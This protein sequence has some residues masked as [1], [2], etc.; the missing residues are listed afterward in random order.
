VTST[1]LAPPAPAS[2]PAASHTLALEQQ[3][4]G[5]FARG[6]LHDAADFLERAAQH[7]P[8]APGLWNRLGMARHALGQFELARA[9]SDRLLALLPQSPVAWVNRAHTLEALQL[10]EEALACV[11]R[12]IDCDARPAVHWLHRGLVLG[13]LQRHAD[14]LAA[15]DQALALDE[16]LA[17]AWAQRAGPL[18][19]AH[20]HE[21]ALASSERALALDPQLAVGWEQRGYCLLALGQAATALECLETAVRLDPG[22]AAAR[23]SRGA[24]LLSLGQFERGWEDYEVRAAARSALAGSDAP[25][26]NPGEALAGRTLALRAEQGLG[27]TLQFCRYAAV[28]AR[29]GTPVVLTAPRSLVRLLNSLGGGVRVVPEDEPLPPHALQCPL[30]SLPQRLGTCADTIPAAVPYLAPPAG[31]LRAWSARLADLHP[32]GRVRVGLAFSG[33]SRFN[34]DHNRSVPP[35]RLAALVAAFPQVEWHLLQRDVRPGDTEWIARLGLV[36]HRAMLEDFCETAALAACMDL[37][38]SVDTSIAHLAG[39]LALPLCVL[40]PHVPEWR[41]MLARADSPWYPSARLL[42][43]PAPGDWDGALQALVPLLTAL[44]QRA[45]AA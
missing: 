30:L 33:E 41:W 8:D 17:P 4:D 11:D 29:S 36:D 45:A 19:V 13:A 15:F 9:A 37:V 10:H 14:A 34:N 12:A 28:L 6:L 27:D 16:R 44:T 39:A 5:L 40:L 42:R 2:P 25:L 31:L 22:N 26:W 24:L 38:V 32:P 1:S 7:E 20:R 18:R 21:E 43:Q 3:A 23:F 35:E